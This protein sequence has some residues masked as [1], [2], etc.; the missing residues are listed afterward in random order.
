[1]KKNYTKTITKSA[2][3]ASLYVI[4][5]FLS[6]MFGLANGAIQV[7]LSESLT[8]LPCFTTAAIP[9][10]TI[11]CMISNLLTGCA[12][13]DVI[14]GSLATFLGAL[15]TYMLRK[16]MRIALLSPIIANMLIIPFVL[17]Y[18]YGLED[19]W[20]FLMLT[21][22]AGEIISAGILGYLLGK[23]VKKYKIP[24]LNN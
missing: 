11:G 24:F 18:A 19:A 5:T 3:I 17:I 14:F 20:W 21:V 22:G 16:N 1:M 23:T 2:I 12:M 13:I 4:L 10:L 8:I 9:G 7:R 15:G 6:N